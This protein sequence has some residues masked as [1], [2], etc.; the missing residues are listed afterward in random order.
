MRALSRI[1]PSLSPDQLGRGRKYRVDF[2]VP[3]E[4]PGPPNYGPQP[5]RFG[6]R[7]DMCAFF[8]PDSS[9]CKKYEVPVKVYY[10]CD[11]WKRNPDLPITVV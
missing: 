5:A 2:W 6:P 9:Q 4:S 1:R 11:S 10:S 3:M 7:C 8:N